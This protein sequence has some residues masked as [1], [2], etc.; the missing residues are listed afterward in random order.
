MSRYCCVAA[1]RPLNTALGALLNTV[2]NVKD[3][4]ELAV[5][6]AALAEHNRLHNLALTIVGRPDP[7]DAILSDGSTTTWME[8]TDAFFS[9]DWARDL[10]THAADVAHRPM[11]Q[12]GYFEPDA[13][14]ADAFCRCVLDKAGKATYAGC[15]AQYGPG[16]LVVGLESPWLDE[17]T[18]REINEAWAALGSPDISATFAHVYLGYRDDSGNRATAWPGT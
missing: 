12:R 15:I 14:L 16:I 17:D 10:T 1:A 7:P 9:G 18:I 4:H 5:L 13:Q 11:E 6:N 3:R 8:H 2:A